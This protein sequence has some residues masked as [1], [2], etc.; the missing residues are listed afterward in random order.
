ML[1]AIDPKRT[2]QLTSACTVTGTFFVG[3]LFCMGAYKHAYYVWVPII[4][5]LRYLRYKT[6]YSVFLK[7]TARLLCIDEHS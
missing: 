5:I 6:L 2:Q 4:L 3:C 7:I 1:M